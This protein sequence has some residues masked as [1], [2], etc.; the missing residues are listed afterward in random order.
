MQVLIDTH[1][2]LVS[3]ISNTFI[4]YLYPN[5][6]VVS[7][8][9]ESGFQNKRQEGIFLIE[10]TLSF[11]KQ[12]KPQSE[13]RDPSKDGPPNQRAVKIRPERLIAG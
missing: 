10:N 5:A 13:I 6:F 9:I 3:S 8:D 7:D 4:R 11:L 2:R 12:L 1:E